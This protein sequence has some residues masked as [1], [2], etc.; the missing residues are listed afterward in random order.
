MSWYETVHH[1]WLERQYNLKKIY[2]RYNHPANVS[3]LL[4]Y[5]AASLGN[6]LPSIPDIVTVSISRVQMSNNNFA[7][8]LNLEERTTLFQNVGN[9]SPIDGASYPRRADTSGTPLHKPTHS[10]V[11]N[12]YFINNFSTHSIHLVV[13]YRSQTLCSSTY[14]SVLKPITQNY[15]E[16]PESAN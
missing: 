4:C 16:L 9:Q 14:V 11:V 8:T 10:H 15:K 5:D 13:H 12:T 3:F 6:W 2:T 7:G 1:L